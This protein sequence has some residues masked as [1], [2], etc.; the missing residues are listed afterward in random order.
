MQG[1]VFFGKLPLEP[2]CF[3]LHLLAKRYGES[4]ADSGNCIGV[5]SDPELAFLAGLGG[6]AGLALHCSFP[7]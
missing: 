1:G 6:T 3:T 7:S 5:R 2:I 4:Q